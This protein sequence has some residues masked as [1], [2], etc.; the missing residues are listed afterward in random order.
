MRNAQGSAPTTNP[1]PLRYGGI[2]TEGF[3]HPQNDIT[4][5]LCG[6]E[7]PTTKHVTGFL[8][9]PPHVTAVVT[10]MSAT[11]VCLALSRLPR[12]ALPMLVLAGLT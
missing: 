9:S 4:M 12:F 10:R 1:T 5:R 8:T 6:G 7:G 3:N 11:C 2:S